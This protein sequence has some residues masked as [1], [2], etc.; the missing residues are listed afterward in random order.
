MEQTEQG[1]VEPRY[2][3]STVVDLV[4]ALSLLIPRSGEVGL[5]SV[6]NAFALLAE[7]RFPLAF[8]EVVESPG[9]QLGLGGAMFLVIEGPV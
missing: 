4:R 1:V 8:L 5:K 9:H 2:L 6:D 7:Q 3:D